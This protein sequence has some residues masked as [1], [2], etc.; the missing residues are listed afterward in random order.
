MINSFSGQ[1]SFL[2]NFSPATVRVPLIMPKDRLFNAP[3]VELPTVE[4]AFVVS[5][6]G[7]WL[8]FRLAANVKLDKFCEMTPGQAKRLGRKIKLRE[9]WD[10]HKVEVMLWLLRQKFAQGSE[11]AQK[12]LGTGDEMLVEGNNWH[13]RYWGV[14]S[15]RR[16]SSCGENVLGVL[17][18]QVRDELLGADVWDASVVAAFQ[19]VINGN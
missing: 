16:C 3:M 5:K 15:C 13:D 10:D 14:C 19:E 2:S 7:T 11:L 1:H 9:G 6:V 17:L 12:L 18:M 8:S 4:H